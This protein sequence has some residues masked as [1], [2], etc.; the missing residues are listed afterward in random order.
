MDTTLH[1]KR[2]KPG[3]GGT[4]GKRGVLVV[5]SS[6]GFGKTLVLD[7]SA[8]VIGRD[9]SCDFVLDDPLAS[10]KHCMIRS[11]GD[12]AFRIEDLGST[13]P[14]YVNA[15]ALKKP[16]LLDY[17]DRILV[18]DTILRFFLEEDLPT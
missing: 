13:N 16:A 8:L 3:W 11:E 18:G 6:M 1:D 2:G 10:R 4:I 15:K 12:G 7:R 9:P 17:G 5:L 14:V